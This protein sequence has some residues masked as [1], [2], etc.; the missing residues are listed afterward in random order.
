MGVLE[1]SVWIHADPERVWS[2]YVDPMRIP[3]WQTGS[4]VIEDVHG[5]A[6]APGSTYVSRRSPGKARTTVVA[7]ERPRR[8]VTRTDA[9]FGLRFD[10]VSR[11]QAEGDGTRLDLHVETHWPRGLGLLGRLLE[12]VFLSAR[13]GRKELANLKSLVER[14][15]TSG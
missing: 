8:L 11:L 12:G 6:D 3:D 14:E 9:Y 10:V 1:Q 4:P 13:E 7:A 5:A 15:A 2:V